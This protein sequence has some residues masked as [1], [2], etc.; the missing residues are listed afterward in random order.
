MDSFGGCFPKKMKKQHQAIVRCYGILLVIFLKKFGC[1]MLWDSFGSCFIF[2]DSMTIFF[3]HLEE[4]H[5]AT[6]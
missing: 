3:P 4:E 6:T 5:W 1:M 2:F